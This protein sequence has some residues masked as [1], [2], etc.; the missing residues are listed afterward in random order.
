MLHARTARDASRARKRARAG[1]ER[2]DDDDDEDSAGARPGQDVGPPTPPMTATA[3]ATRA[4]EDEDEEEEKGG[5]RA[6]A[7]GRHAHGGTRTHGSNDVLALLR[8]L[9]LATSA[10]DDV[11]GVDGARRAVPVPPR[12]ASAQLVHVHVRTHSRE[13]DVVLEQRSLLMDDGWTRKEEAREA[14]CSSA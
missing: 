11:D 7:S 2:S 10:G 13:D 5:A 14:R 12:P 9:D 6:T 8:A 3:W 4:R 1:D